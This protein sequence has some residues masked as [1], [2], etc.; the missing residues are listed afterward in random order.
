MTMMKTTSTYEHDL[1]TEKKKF[2]VYYFLCA[3]SLANTKERAPHETFFRNHETN[4]V[5]EIILPS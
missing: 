5:P 2:L 4:H 1:R 3:T